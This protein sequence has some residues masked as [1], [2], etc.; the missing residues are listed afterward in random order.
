MFCIVLC[1]NFLIDEP[2]HGAESAPMEAESPEVGG[3]DGLAGG[4]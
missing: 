3:P 4:G 1:R 2:Q